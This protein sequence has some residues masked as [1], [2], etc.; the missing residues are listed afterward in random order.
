[1]ATD[2]VIA[3]AETKNE[4]DRVVHFFLE[5]KLGGEREVLVKLL[6]TC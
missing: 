4:G 1:M 5:L 2:W 3:L 6:I